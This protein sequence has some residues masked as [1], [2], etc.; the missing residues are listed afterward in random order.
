MGSYLP[1]HPKSGNSLISRTHSVGFNENAF[2][3]LYVLNIHY[4]GMN[5]KRIK[6]DYTDVNDRLI[7]TV[8]QLSQS[9]NA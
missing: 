5:R 4:H 9:F 8:G 6:T 1:T 2:F 7:D 3:I